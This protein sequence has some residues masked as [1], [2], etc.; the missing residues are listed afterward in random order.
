MSKNK[1]SIIAG[2]I[3]VAF[4][5]LW[6]SD[7]L[8]KAAAVSSAEKYMKEQLYG[9]FYEAE[10]AEYSPAHDS[11]FVYFSGG[12]NP[13]GEMGTTRHI[14]VYYRWFP[15]FVWYDSMYPG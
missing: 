12:P 5:L 4:L 11:Y 7:I 3:C 14:G 9:E 2:I 1:I 10:Y 8:P 15:F 6:F 13:S